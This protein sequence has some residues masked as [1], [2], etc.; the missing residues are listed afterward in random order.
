MLLSI[1]IPSRAEGNTLLKT[2]EQLQAF[3]AIP[4]ELIV[5]ESGEPSACAHLVDVELRSK[6]GRA[7]QMNTGAAVANGE[8]LLFLHADTQLPDNLFRFVSTLSAERALWGFFP[9]RLSGAHRAF[10]LIEWFISRR[11]AITSVATGDQ[12]FVARRSTFLSL[13]GFSDMPL[14]EDVAISKRLR[15]LAKPN[16]ADTP[17]RTSSRRWEQRGIVATVVLMWRLRLAYFLGVSP[18]KLAEKYR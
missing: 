5:V 13:G 1:I 16:I 17:V 6:A 14:M 12:A 8:Y 10:R 3:R 11:S 7:L 18:H 9:V 15:R 4:C 2:L